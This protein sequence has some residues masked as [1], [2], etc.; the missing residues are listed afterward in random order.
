MAD[1]LTPHFR[2]AWFLQAEGSSRTGRQVDDTA[3]AWSA[4]DAESELR[5]VYA[6]GL[7]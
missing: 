3:E 1:S 2:E 5:L 4:I 6:D 7:T